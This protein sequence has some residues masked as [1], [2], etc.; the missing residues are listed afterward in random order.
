MKKILSLLILLFIVI[1]FTLPIYSSESFTIEEDLVDEEQQIID[2]YLDGKQEEIEIEKSITH[3][4]QEMEEIN[5]LKETD[6]MEWYKSYR[7]IVCEYKDVVGV[8]VTAF[9]VYT[10]D[11]VNLIC[12][13][14][15]T[16]CYGK[17]FESKVM[18]ANVIFNRIESDLYSS[19]VSVVITSPYQFA[20]SREVI[21][22]D[23]LYA[24]LYAYEIED[25]T[26]GSLSFHSNEK[27]EKFDGRSYVFTDPN[28][29]HHFYK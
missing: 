11:E 6:K 20:Y 4:N 22:E 16:E 26:N 28:S 13:A 8:P 17:S 5:H 23:T 18:V 2:E 25:L 29:G 15:E 1:S 7:N 9:E 24:V 21:P 14:V 12:K 3:M 27:T 10:E 19:D